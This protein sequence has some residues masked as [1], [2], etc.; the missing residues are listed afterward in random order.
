MSE[1]IEVSS[2]LYDVLLRVYNS[3]KEEELQS[4]IYEGTHV[5]TWRHYKVKK[6]PDSN[7]IVFYDDNTN[8]MDNNSSLE[9]QKEIKNLQKEL[10][11]K[12]NLLGI[13]F[14]VIP[15]LIWLKDLNG[16]YM[17][18]NQ[19]FE[20][21]FGAKEIDILGKTDFDFVEADLANFFRKNDLKNGGKGAPLSPIFHQL[22]VRK[23]KISFPV[24]VLNLGGIANVSFI[25]SHYPQDTFSSDVGPGNCLIDKWIKKK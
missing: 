12:K 24:C 8:L 17:Y 23:N 11:I 20:Q 2:A 21:F 6:L 15:D 13:I 18:C 1:E 10:S 5:K 16:V 14:D 4:V 7:L 3:S 19:R 9:H 25:Y 22:M